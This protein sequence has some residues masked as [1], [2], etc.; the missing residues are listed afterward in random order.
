M[1]RRPIAHVCSFTSLDDLKAKHEVDAVTVLA[2]LSHVKAYS[3]FDATRTQRL[4]RT[5]DR[6]GNAGWIRTTGGAYPWIEFEIT[7]A[8][9]AVL[10]KTEPK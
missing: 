6:I 5:M 4:A 2:A 7:D 1:S 3:V 8:G 10:A 9:R